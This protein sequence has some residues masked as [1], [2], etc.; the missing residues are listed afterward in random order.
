MQIPDSFKEKIADTFYD[1]TI[2]TYSSEEVVDDEG[3]AKIGTTALSTF[4]GNVN[5][6]DLAKIQEDYGLTDKID[7]SITTD[8]DVDTGSIIGYDDITYM[9]VKSIPFDSH[10]LIVGKKW[11]LAL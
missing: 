4:E 11:S 2:S 3:D 1:N 5:F 8:E 9:V 6:S 10:N 7:I